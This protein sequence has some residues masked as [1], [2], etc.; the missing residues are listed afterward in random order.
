M[1]EGKVGLQ[2]HHR[3]FHNREDQ[4]TSG[5]DHHIKG[6]S[7][8]QPAPAGRPP[9][10]AGRPL[11]HRAR[12]GCHLPGH[13]RSSRRSNA[14]LMSPGSRQDVNTRRRRPP[15]A[16]ANVPALARLAIWPGR[17]SYVWTENVPAGQR[18]PGR[19]LR[20]A[21]RSP[22]IS[23]LNPGARG[24]NAQG[25]AR[26]AVWCGRGRRQRADRS[27]GAT[28][29]GRKGNGSGRSVRRHQCCQ[30]VSAVRGG[31]R[32]RRAGGCT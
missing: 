8:T 21:R 3:F 20:A 29:K 22:C 11:G 25:L 2:P 4:A 19:R 6:K 26:S 15:A 1:V 5:S 16:V 30:A 23:S 10:P 32:R 14:L 28:G 31:S 12:H 9:A 13:R 18:K 27:G 7:G 24:S 17:T